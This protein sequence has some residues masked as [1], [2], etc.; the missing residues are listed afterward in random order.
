MHGGMQNRIFSK[1][2]DKHSK[3]LGE[4]R[5][6][7]QRSLLGLFSVLFILSCSY[8]QDYIRG[9]EIHAKARWVAVLPLV[10][11][12]TFPNAGRIVLDLLTTELYA[13]TDFQILEQTEMLK[14]L[15]GNEDDL[16]QVL[17][18]AV[19]IRVGD[20]L[21]V[22]TIIFGSVTEYRY[23]RGLDEAPVV[24]VNIRML[25]IKTDRI[26]WSGSKSGM[27]G[28]FW[29]CEDS[30]NRLAQKVCYDLVLSMTKDQS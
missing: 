1:S 24:G 7:L 27:G 26:L 14:K 11:L 4:T 22:D 25:D 15:K 30:L 6:K 29:F 21:G 2:M 18:K 12:T 8:Q 16:D 28:C 3:I 17:D 10:N 9:K 20:A 19:A 23:K 5:M 13:N